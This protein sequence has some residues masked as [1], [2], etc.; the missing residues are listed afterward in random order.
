MI[1]GNS[2]G[3]IQC[4]TVTENSMGEGIP[5][6][7][8]VQTVRGWIDMMSGSTAYTTYNA[9]LEESTHVWVMDYTDLDPS[10]SDESSRMV[11][12]GKTYDV[13]YIDN[14]MEL[15]QHLEIFLKLIG[16]Q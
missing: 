6:W 13:T 16:G 4:M 2:T 9:K 11:I 7:Q 15:N 5:E 1:G 10:I 8:D 14:P 12:N 3:I